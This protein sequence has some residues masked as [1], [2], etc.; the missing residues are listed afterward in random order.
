MHEQA[1]KMQ[2]Q[3][4]HTVQVLNACLHFLHHFLLRLCVWPEFGC[5]K[6]FAPRH[7]CGVPD[8]LPDPIFIAIHISSVNVSVPGCA[9]QKPGRSRG[10]RLLIGIVKKKNRR[11]TKRVSQSPASA[12]CILCS[13][14]S[15]FTD[16]D[17]KPTLCEGEGGGGVEK[18]E[19]A[20]SAYIRHVCMR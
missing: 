10:E 14:V 9:R 11:K 5:D 20:F 6:N 18:G 16:K 8:H 12:A 15:S 7:Y 1:R 3:T 2:W 17:P 4:Y 13:Q 19:N